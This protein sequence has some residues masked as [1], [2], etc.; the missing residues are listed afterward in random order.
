MDFK[1]TESPYLIVNST[2]LVELEEEVWGL[3]EAGYLPSGSLQVI[4]KEKAI[5]VFEPIFYQPMIKTSHLP[6]FDK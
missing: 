5:N 4:H 1:T 6:K 2:D 3:I